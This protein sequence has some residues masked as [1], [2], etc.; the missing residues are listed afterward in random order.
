MNKFRFLPIVSF[1]ILGYII[2]SC[3]QGDGVRKNDNALSDKHFAD[4]ADSRYW[5]NKANPAPA[6][7]SEM[8]DSTSK[9]A[10]ADSASTDKMDAKKEEPKVD[11]KKK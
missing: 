6:E 10:T 5:Q 11:N 9:S 2:S 4:T 1:I 8:T 7:A 3:V